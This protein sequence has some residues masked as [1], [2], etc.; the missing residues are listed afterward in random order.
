MYNALASLLKVTGPRLEPSD[1][2]R[3][4]QAPNDLYNVTWTRQ[5]GSYVWMFWSASGKQL[6]LPAVQRATLY[7]PL[8]GEQLEL[9]GGEGVVVPLKSSLQLLVWR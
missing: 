8:T 1:A 4:E 7:D 6:R 2:P 9:Q 5:D 3:F